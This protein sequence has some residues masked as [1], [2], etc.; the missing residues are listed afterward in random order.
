MKYVTINEKAAAMALDFV[1]GANVR[2]GI[3]RLYELLANA[4]E[5]AYDEGVE[6]GATGLKLNAVAAYDDGY[7]AGYEQGRHDIIEDESEGFYDASEDDEDFEPGEDFAFSADECQ[8]ETC[9]VERAEASE[10]DD[11]LTTPVPLPP[12]QEQRR[13]TAP[14]AWS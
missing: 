10:Q 1:V 2:V 8:C 11:T 13:V 3:E 9:T 12:M 14:Y 5:A 4:T 7:D 6:F